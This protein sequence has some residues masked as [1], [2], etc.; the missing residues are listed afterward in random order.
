M[1]IGGGRVTFRPFFVSDLFFVSAAFFVLAT[2]AAR[3]AL[4]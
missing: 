1:Q 2:I 3:V 4:A